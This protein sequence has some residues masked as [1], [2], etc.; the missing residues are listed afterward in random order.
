M[1]DFRGGGFERA[2]IGAHAIGQFRE[3]A[4]DLD[5][6]FFGKLHEPIIQ[7]DGFERLD[8]NSLSRGAGAVDHARERRGD[9]K[10]GLE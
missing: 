1:R 2:A 5:G 10:R 4:G 9:P 8:E 6:F 3:N 7:I